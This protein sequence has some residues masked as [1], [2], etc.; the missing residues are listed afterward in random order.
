MPDIDEGRD[1][2]GYG[3]EPPDA[4]WPGGAR[5]ALSLVLNIEEGAE[6][7]LTAGDPHN[8][9]MYEIE[10]TVV[11]APH[12]ALASHFEYGSRVGYWRIADV[13]ESHGA[14]CTLNACGRAFVATPWL[15]R[16]ALARGHE[17]MCHGWRW[18]QHVGMA[19]AEERDV[20]ARCVRVI[21]DITG[22]RPVGWHVK[23]QTSV[24]TR[25]LLVEEGGFLYDSN[26]YNDDL[27]WVDHAH[28]RPHIVLP[29]SFDTNDMRFFGGRGFALAEHFSTYCCDAFDWLWREGARTPRMMT[30]GLHTRIV[31]RPGRIAGL[32]R[33]LRHVRER[34]GVWI[35]R[36]DEIARHWRAR[37]GLPP[38]AAADGSA[39]P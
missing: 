4:R 21:R 27:P 13:L 38:F 8:E 2:L 14:V 7:S 11:G 36:R 24:N 1:F 6:Y 28:G 18:E 32:D 34:G 37:V 26:A 30:V 23:S 22:T 31:G 19:E 3:R 20:I 12:H 33:F 5:V 10:E 15:A 25:R 35:A 17:V 16:D 39:A 9:S 29:Y